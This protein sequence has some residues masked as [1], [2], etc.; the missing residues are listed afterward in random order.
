MV[1]LGGR[2]AIHKLG[3]IGREEDDFIRVFEE[4]EEYYIG[5]FVQGFGFIDVKFKKRDC[6]SLTKEEVDHLNGRWHGIN[7]HP[8]YQ[9]WVDY[10]GNVINKSK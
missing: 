10:E 2:P 4:D 1:L 9:I 3:N 5:N 7:N 8:Y 6:R